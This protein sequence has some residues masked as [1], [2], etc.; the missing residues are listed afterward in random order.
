GLLAF[1]IVC[2]AGAGFFIWFLTG[3]C[4][5]PSVPGEFAAINDIRD[6]VRVLE[7]RSEK[8]ARQLHAT[9][10]IHQLATH[11]TRRQG[12]PEVQFLRRRLLQLSSLV[13]ELEKLKTTNC[14]S[15][16]RITHV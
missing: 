4:A 11:P 2:A 15:T 6:E 1:L 9:A 8:L 14:F 10:L 7:I 5:H 12:E 16:D 13:R 3:L